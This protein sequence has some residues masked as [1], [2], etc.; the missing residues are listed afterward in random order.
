MDCFCGNSKKTSSWA[1]PYYEVTRAG[2]TVL[3]DDKM[4]VEVCG[5]CGVVHQTNPPY[6]SKD[7]IV[8]FYSKY[9]PVS[10]EYRAKSYDHDRDLARKRCREYGITSG[11]EDRILDVGAGSGAF[12][13][14]CRAR[15]AVAFGCEIA[16]YASLKDNSFIYKR[17]FEEINFPVDYFKIVT[18]HD[19][20]EHTLNPKSFVA[21]LFRVTDQGG[22]CII[23]IPDFYS[24]DGEH[25]WKKEHLWYF[26]AEQLKL[27]LKDAGFK[28]E[29]IKKPIASKIVFYCSKPI[30]ERKTILLPPGLGDSFWS[31]TKL[32]AFIAKKRIGIPDIFIAS[33]KDK[34]HDGHKRSFPFLEMFPFIHVTGE[35][36]HANGPNKAIWREA[37]AQTG[38]TVFNGVLG[39]DYFISYNGHLRV[40]KKME[41]VDP[42][43]ATNWRPPMFKSLEQE[44]F[45]RECQGNYGKYI[46]V[47]W[48]LFGTYIHW[49]RQF[50]VPRIA[51]YLNKLHQ[52]TG[53]TIVFTGAKWDAEDQNL[54]RVMQQTTSYIDLTGKTTMQKLFG[55]LHGA[56]MV[57]G[58]PSGLTITAACFNIKTLIIWNDYYNR[59]FA[60]H[61]APDDVKNKTYFIENT[62]GLTVDGLIETT[63]SI[64]NNEKYT[65]RQIVID[66][67]NKS[68]NPPDNLPPQVKPVRSRQIKQHLPVSCISGELIKSNGKL[69]I[70]CVLKTGGCFDNDYVLNLKNMVTRNIK[71]KH[72]FVALSDSQHLDTEH[73]PLLNNLDG[74][75]SKLELF[76]LHGPVLYIDLDTVLIGDITDLAEGVRMMP[77]GEVRMLIP[78]NPARRRAGNWASGVMAWHG[79]FRYVIDEFNY[80]RFGKGWDQVYIFRT[81]QK[82]G[83]DI[84]SVN[85]FMPIHSWKRHCST[86]VPSD[87]KMICFHGNQKPH[88]M[89]DLK[90]VKEYW[91]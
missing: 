17:D 45:Q 90:I 55:L 88:N 6:C 72:R 24:S 91:R 12:V 30:Q 49:T 41:D 79:D 56:E 14:E 13:D 22:T 32:Q 39:C 60:W 66:H 36:R 9:Q 34:K 70:A 25:H 77:K 50:P 15:G 63:A 61:C 33:P 2:D 74:W 87:A 43:L 23:D 71:T 21:E 40:G 4:A 84:K 52:E 20:L 68:L 27:L 16:E 38:R 19:V 31:V 83:V 37:Y 29:K 59:Q 54:K 64:I 57:I 26:T 18:C 58:Y 67:D 51:E 7:Q 82:H 78:F 10:G 69:T 89:Q 46:V 48:P 44:N 65:P 1:K 11:S 85:E 28:I 53:C 3:S 8:Q 5:K 42:D 47:Y 76:R 86:G 35:I 75:W 81:L 62:K 73:I 80:H